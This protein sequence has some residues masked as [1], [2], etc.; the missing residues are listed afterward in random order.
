VS[1]VATARSIPGTLRQDITIDG[2]HRLVT[3]EPV[4]VGG[5][6]SAPSPHE[7]LP[8][9]VAACVSTTLVMFA[10]RKEWELG[11][12]EVAVDYDHR[13]T[14]PRFDVVV[15]FGGALTQQQLDVLERVAAACPVRRAL[16]A[17]VE[18][19][20]RLVAGGLASV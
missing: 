20:E 1:L 12:V 10:R 19:D 8:A 9:A 2:S 16:E 4:A 18:F 3:D 5:D 6:G 13:A 14:P 7:L 15:S 11:S 17:S